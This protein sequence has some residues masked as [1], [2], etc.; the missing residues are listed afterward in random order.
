[1]FVARSKARRT[2][3]IGFGI[4][5]LGKEHPLGSKSE[6]QGS[7]GSWISLTPGLPQ[8]LRKSREAPAGGLERC[9]SGEPGE[10]LLYVHHFCGNALVGSLIS[11]LYIGIKQHIGSFPKG[12]MVVNDSETYIHIRLLNNSQGSEFT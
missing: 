7:N 10:L 8:C 6:S 4:Q 2:P 5:G 11:I 3:S 1:M 12:N 9:R